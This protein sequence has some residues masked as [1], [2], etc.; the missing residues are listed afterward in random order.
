MR[1]SS[2]GS[3]KSRRIGRDCFGEALQHPNV[4]AFWWPRFK[5]IAGWIVE[6]E[7]ERRVLIAQ[8]FGEI[9]GTLALPAARGAFT[10]SG[11]A[12]RIDRLA[13]GGLA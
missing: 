10:L 3:P 11:K 4:R 12:D 1:S 6:A 9:S 2:G 7:R 5:R 13:A 8:S